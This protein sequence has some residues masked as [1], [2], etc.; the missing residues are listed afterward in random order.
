MLADIHFLSVPDVC[1]GNGHYLLRGSDFDMSEYTVEVVGAMKVTHDLDQVRTVPYFDDY[2]KVNLAVFEDIHGDLTFYWVVSVTESTVRSSSLDFNL[3]YC[4]P[5]DL[6]E[7]G[8]ELNG[9]F[10]RYPENIR[11]YLKDAITDDALENS[12]YNPLTTWWDMLPIDYKIGYSSK[13]R[14]FWV[15]VTSYRNVITEGNSDMIRYGFPAIYDLDNPVFRAKRVC[16]PILVSGSRVWFPEL[17]DFITNPERFGIPADSIQNISVSPI[18][19]FQWSVS[20]GESGTPAITITAKDQ[21]GNL[22]SPI[23]VNEPVPDYPDASTS[24]YYGLVM[25]DAHDVVESGTEYR[26]YPVSADWVGESLGFSD[27]QRMLGALS[28]CDQKATA[29]SNVPTEILTVSALSGDHTLAYKFKCVSDYTGIYLHIRFD[30]YPDKVIIIPCGKLPWVGD[31]WEQY[32]FRELA[33]DREAASNAS[34]NA[35]I[36]ALQGLMTGGFGTLAGAIG[37]TEWAGGQGAFRGYGVQQAGAGLT[38]MMQSLFNM[39]NVRRSEEQNLRLTEHS[40]KAAAGTGYSTGYGF[41]F[42]LECCTIGFGV[43]LQMPANMT[44]EY[45]EDYISEHGYPCEGKVEG[46]AQ[47]GFYQGRILPSVTGIKAERLVDIFASGFKFVV[48]G[49]VE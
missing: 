32:R 22:R 35:K 47:E 25:L 1:M 15:E 27:M 34:E 42:I 7:D 37:M 3:S 18:C 28:V 8:D 6:Y 39:D 48:K 9:I 2:D 21:N 49:G 45:F 40:M 38:G 44:V 26:T 11:T 36:E 4:A 19:P 24:T 5:T 13:T 29:V 23:V 20:Q 17:L 30:D 43:L 33:T 10:T 31:A 12:V 14:M 46:F 41:D 16:T